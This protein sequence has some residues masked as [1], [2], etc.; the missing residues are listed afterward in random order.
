MAEKNEGRVGLGA[1]RDPAIL[2]AAESARRLDEP[3]QCE[4]IDELH[5]PPPSP[6]EIIAYLEQGSERILRLE[7]RVRILGVK[8]EA[9]DT[10]REILSVMRS[11]IFGHERDQAYRL[12]DLAERLI[13]QTPKEDPP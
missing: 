6:E 10:I 1:G 8:A 9:Y 12:K 2:S 4:D 5:D 3:G 7:E 13:A 11:Q